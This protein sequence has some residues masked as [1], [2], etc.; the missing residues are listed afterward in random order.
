MRQDVAP[1][2]NQN[3]GNNKK[4]LGMGTAAN[5]KKVGAKGT[6]GIFA[7]AT[8]LA[9]KEVGVSDAHM[10]QAVTWVVA[11]NLFG[12]TSDKANA[13]IEGIWKEYHDSKIS[14]PEAQNRVWKLASDDVNAQAA[15]RASAL[16]KL[17]EANVPLKQSLTA[18][19]KHEKAKQGKL[20]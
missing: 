6:Y 1:A 4:A 15:V 19:L 5:P 9:A 20:L 8:R 10:M 16:A 3:F 18:S 14:Q 17:T 2:V 7:D 12:E 13:A 11:R